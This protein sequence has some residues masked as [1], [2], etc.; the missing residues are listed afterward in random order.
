MR[1]DFDKES[2]KIVRAAH[3]AGICVIGV[4]LVLLAAL[5]T[6]V[7]FGSKW[8]ISEYQDWKEHLMQPETTIERIE[9]AGD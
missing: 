3:Y 1:N 7:Y 5:I 8:V 9:N 4:Q 2:H 6:G